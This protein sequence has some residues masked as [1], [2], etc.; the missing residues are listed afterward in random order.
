MKNIATKY[1]VAIMM[2]LVFALTGCMSRGT[3]D[4]ETGLAEVNE[5]LDS[6]PTETPQ[7]TVA[8][9]ESVTV[10][11]AAESTVNL[12]K[13]AGK[14]YFHATG[15]DIQMGEAT[16]TVAGSTMYLNVEN[17]DSVDITPIKTIKFTSPTEGKSEETFMFGTYELRG[18]FYLKE[19]CCTGGES[20][21]IKFVSADG[22]SPLEYLHMYRQSDRTENE[23]QFNS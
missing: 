2:I 13:Y 5:Y 8:T 22:T 4:V 6:L 16:V 10:P 18:I 17:I 19:D 7:D 11:S 9:T 21:S 14:W 20:M 23:C 1:G 12:E 15:H 3:N